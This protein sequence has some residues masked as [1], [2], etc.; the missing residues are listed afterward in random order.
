MVFEENVGCYSFERYCGIRTLSEDSAEIFE[1]NAN[2]MY[3]PIRCKFY[4]KGSYE[5]K[6]TFDRFKE[7]Q[8]IYKE[9]LDFAP[10]EE[11]RQVYKDFYYDE[12]ITP[13]EAL[14]DDIAAAI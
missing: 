5:M 11:D 9:T 1:S 4:K 3:K 8:K 12:D 7:L 10:S 14:R 2:A 13:E 6:M